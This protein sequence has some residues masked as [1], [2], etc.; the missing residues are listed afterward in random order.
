M[1]LSTLYTD[2]IPV[3]LPNGSTLKVE[4]LPS[5]RENVAFGSPSFDQITHVIE[6]VAQSIAMSMQ[7]VRPSKATVKFG[8]EIGIQQGG[9]FAV[10]VQGSSKANLEI[11]LEW[12]HAST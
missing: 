7:T 11:T 6:G 2:T 12:N 1:E 5:G 3:N 8:L 4:V 9:L 10:L